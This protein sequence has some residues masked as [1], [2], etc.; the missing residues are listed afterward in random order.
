MR[1][2][3]FWTPYVAERLLLES[4]ALLLPDDCW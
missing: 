1:T 4:T 3:E 2:A